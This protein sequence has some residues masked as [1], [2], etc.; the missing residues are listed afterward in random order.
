MKCRREREREAALS[1]ICSG[2]HFVL[3]YYPN[4]AT[5]SIKFPRIQDKIFMSQLLVPF[6]PLVQR[7]NFQLKLVILEKS[8]LSSVSASLAVISRQHLPRSAFDSTVCHINNSPTCCK[9]SLSHDRKQG[10]TRFVFTHVLKT[11]WPEKQLTARTAHSRPHSRTDFPVIKKTKSHTMRS[12][13]AFLATCVKKNL[14][15]CSKPKSF[16]KPKS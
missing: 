16:D 13:P 7:L 4:K 12:F 6:S 2:V 10:G 5:D 11:S 8:Q 14:S 15:K 9:D 1:S 3:T